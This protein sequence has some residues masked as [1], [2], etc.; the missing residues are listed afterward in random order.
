MMHPATFENTSPRIGN[1]QFSV[2][3]ETLAAGNR[4]SNI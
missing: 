3:L 1:P 2:N 4:L